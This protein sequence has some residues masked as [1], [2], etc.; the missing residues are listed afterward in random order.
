MV[1][2]RVPVNEI[3]KLRKALG[4][5]K[6]KIVPKAY[7]VTSDFHEIEVDKEIKELEEFKVG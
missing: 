2:Y 7:L 3:E 4:E 5:G 6:K 1:K